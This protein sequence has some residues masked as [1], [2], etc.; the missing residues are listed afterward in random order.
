MTRR[1]SKD[2]GDRLSDLAAIYR[3]HQDYV[4]RILYHCGLETSLIDDALQDV[5]LVVHRRLVDF[6]GRTSIRNWLY[7][8]A[9][10]VASDYRRGTRRGSR[11]LVLVGEDHPLLRSE[12]AGARVEAA[13]IVEQ[14]LEQ[15][16]PDKRRVFLLSELEGMTAVEIGELEGLNV[17]TVYARL[18]AARQRFERT[19]ARHMARKKREEPW[20]G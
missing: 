20:T 17:N 18:R 16:D 5:F 13:H 7:G 15:L 12:H 11:K 4:A 6:D 1:D 3:A 9:K 19:L 2:T 10:R 14:F 8:I